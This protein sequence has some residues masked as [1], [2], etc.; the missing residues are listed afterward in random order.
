M[1]FTASSKDLKTALEGAMACAAKR[2]TIPILTCVLVEA[3]GG[4]GGG[5][6]ITASDLD[7][8]VRLTVAA[9]IQQDGVEAIDGT[10]FLNFV[11][12][13]K[14]GEVAIESVKG[15]VKIVSGRARAEI[16]ALPAGH[17]PSLGQPDGMEQFTLDGD[18]LQ[19]ALSGVSAAVSTEETR[20]YLCGVF[21]HAAGCKWIAVTTDGHRLH[22]IELDAPSGGHALP[23]IIVPAKTVQLVQ[24][25]FSKA[26][27]ISLSVSPARISIATDSATLNSKLIDGTY[28]DYNRVIPRDQPYSIKA[29]RDDLIAAIGRASIAA[30]ASGD[31]PAVKLSF[32]K[33]TI[34]V[35]G[36]KGG[37][38]ASS[39]EVDASCGEASFEI[40][41]VAR[42]LLDALAMLEGDDVTISVSDPSSPFVFHGEREGALAVIMPRRV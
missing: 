32:S 15:G 24:K 39:D 28:P 21:L 23:S 22:K 8:E 7:C 14:D 19:K 12:R 2:T 35:S 25:L 4:K 16:P 31:G 9:S 6:F 11:S 37:N 20:Y 3:K 40:G 1:R 26:D 34:T 10:M 36:S 5:V 29:L 42:Y 33:S 38:A 17:F 41:A 13:V 27:R 30:E 18:G